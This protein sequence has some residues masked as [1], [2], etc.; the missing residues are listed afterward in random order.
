MAKRQSNGGG[1]PKNT[2]T[3]EDYANERRQAK[4]GKNR[5][6]KR[7][8]KPEHRVQTPVAFV[9]NYDARDQIAER[10]RKSLER[11]TKQLPRNSFERRIALAIVDAYAASTVNSGNT[12]VERHV[13][14][15]KDAA[16]V[17]KVA[18]YI[19]Q[20]SPMTRRQFAAVVEIAKKRLNWYSTLF[21]TCRRRE[22]RQAELLTKNGSTAEWQTYMN[23]ILGNQEN[24]VAA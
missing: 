6:T 18:E 1:A 12:P 24:Q 2:K 16:Q 17:V 11:M 23:W 10:A 9:R 3:P 15:F 14:R 22:M 20:Q 13:M 4:A 5:K 19:D 21:E 7:T 8:V